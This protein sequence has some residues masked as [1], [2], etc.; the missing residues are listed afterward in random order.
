MLLL[1][2]MKNKIAELLEVFE[3]LPSWEA[4]YKKI[5]QMGK[6][7]EVMPAEFHDEI[8]KVKGCQSQVWLFAQLTPEGKLKLLGDS[9][10]LIVKGLVALLLKIYDNSL[11]NE[12]LT[13]PPQFIKDLGLEEH[14]SP[15]RSNGFYAVLKQIIL[16]AQAFSMSQR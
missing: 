13:T 9:D 8:H 14:L 6:E 12:I 2:T 15:S 3:K 4:K 1:Q 10:A 16:Y 11:P 5:I 7:L